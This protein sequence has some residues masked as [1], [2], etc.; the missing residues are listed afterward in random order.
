MDSK[1]WGLNVSCDRYQFWD[2]VNSSARWDTSRRWIGR[3]EVATMVQLA[4]L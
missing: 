2:T 1:Y 3:S 4:I